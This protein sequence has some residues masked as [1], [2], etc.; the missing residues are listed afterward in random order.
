MRMHIFVQARLHS[1]RLPQKPL[2]KI[3]GKTIFEL[4][5]ER[6]RFVKG[7]E[8]IVLV[9]GPY[10]A[11]GALIQEAERLGLECFCGSEENLLDR[12]YRAS[13][14]FKSDAIVRVTGDNPLVDPLTVTQLIE[15]FL[16]GDCDIAFMTKNF[17]LGSGVDIFSRDILEK[18]FKKAKGASLN[19]AEAIAAL[20]G[21]RRVDMEYEKDYSNL[22]I[23][24]DYE[25]DFQLIKKV[26]EA[27]YPTN[28]RFTLKDVVG[29]LENNVV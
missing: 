23:T 14:A 27:L 9:T 4:L 6:L 8:K 15:R 1:R 20:P 2:L 12:F 16:Q 25:E 13:L 28:P 21:V 19:S 7:A 24:M 11:N 10:E 26:Y 22:R 29:F 18:A 17:P 3:L 5:I